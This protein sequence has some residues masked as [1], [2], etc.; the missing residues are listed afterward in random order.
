MI[1]RVNTNVADI[2]G[3][4]KFN[5]ERTSQTLFNEPVEVLEKGTEFS[6]VRLSDKYEGYLKNDF[7]SE[8]AVEP[9]YMVT[10]TIAVAYIGADER[11]P[12]ATMLPFTSTLKAARRANNFIVCKTKRYG[13]IYVM[14]DDL[15]PINEIPQITRKDML[16]FLECV[17]RFI[18]VPYLWGGK[19]FFGID[20]SGLAQTNYKFFGINLPRDTKDQINAGKEIKREDIQA[21][22]LLFFKGHVAIAI[23]DVTYIHSSAST[24]GV[25]ISSF[26]PDKENYLEHLD[27]GFITARRV[28]EV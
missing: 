3:E 22:D 18:G 12:A 28:I 1:Y 15:I 19:S 11:A 8:D 14:E 7:F 16:M 17:R 21:G 4:P 25:Y 10:A 20:C 27:K 13:D 24:G 23:N 26:E 6:R 5:S 2:W 9:D